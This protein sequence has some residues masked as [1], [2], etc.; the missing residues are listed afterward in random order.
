[1][2]TK[3]VCFKKIGQF[4]VVFLALSFFVINSAYAYYSFMRNGQRT[5]WP[6]GTFTTNHNGDTS[7][8]PGVDLSG[9]NVGAPPNNDTLGLLLAADAQVLRDQ[10]GSGSADCTTTSSGASDFGPPSEPEYAATFSALAAWDILATASVNIAFVC[11]PINIVIAN[12]RTDIFNSGTHLTN[13]INEIVFD[14]TVGALMIAELQLGLDPASLLGVALSY[15]ENNALI[16][17]PRCHRKY[18]RGFYH[19]Q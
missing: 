2:E 1:M 13:G 6:G 4:A 8:I 16:L 19:H 11:N 14:D 15:D 5:L 3:K 17:S 18:H 12:F 10:G 7:T 9:L